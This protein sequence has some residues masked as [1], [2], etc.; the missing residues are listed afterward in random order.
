MISPLPDVKHITITPE[1]EFMIIAC[2]GIW[3]FMSSQEVIDFV[4]V[5]INDGREKLSSICE[6]VR[7]VDV[8]KWVNARKVCNFYHI[9]RIIR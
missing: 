6:E 7:T 2:D 8:W 4:R 5:R 1:D 3:N 9:Q